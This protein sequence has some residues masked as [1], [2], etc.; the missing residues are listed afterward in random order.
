MSIGQNVNLKD[1]IIKK[2][3]G[4]GSITSNISKK[5]KEEKPTHNTVKMTFYVKKNLFEQLRNYAYWD[6]MNLTEAFN[7]VMAD[8]LK[9]KNT[10][11]RPR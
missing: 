5:S 9:G 3:T 8:G 7:T 10:R 2:T 4:K 11:S 1:R 6:R